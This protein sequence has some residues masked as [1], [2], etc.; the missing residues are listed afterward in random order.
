MS[1][2]VHKSVSTIWIIYGII[3]S[4]LVLLSN[5]FI[6]DEEMFM[7]IATLYGILGLII[8][9]I[10]KYNKPEDKIS[11]EDEFRED[12]ENLEQLSKLD[13]KSDDEDISSDSNLKPE[14]D[15][16]NDNSDLKMSTEKKGLNIGLMDKEIEKNK[17]QE[18]IAE[19][20]IEDSKKG[21]PKQDTYSVNQIFEPS[22]AFTTIS[23]NGLFY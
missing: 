4:F 10:A 19:K 3:G 6:V 16:E 11:F 9:I 18:N 14:V 15:I 21:L 23:N 17:K 12:L 22:E 7:Y 13:N 20:M 8:L 1:S 2:I 5:I